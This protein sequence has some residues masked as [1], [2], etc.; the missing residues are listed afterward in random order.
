MLT[1][2]SV[3]LV[4]CVKT[5]AAAP[6]AA[7]D[8]YTSPWFRKARRYV[9]AQGGP[10]FILS[11]QHGLLHPDTV[12]APYEASLT[13]MSRT[14]RR[15]WSGRVHSQLLAR[16]LLPSFLT[17]VVFIAGER[18]RGDLEQWLTYAGRGGDDVQ[19]PLRGL[20]LGEQLA[21]LSQHT[22]PSLDPDPPPTMS[23]GAHVDWNN[24]PD[25][26]PP[27]QEENE[28]Y[29]AFLRARLPERLRRRW[30]RDAGSDPALAGLDT[31]LFRS[32][33]AS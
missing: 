16:R 20:G 18:Y 3:H 6:C 14:E 5:K 9:E 2:K 27:L 12:I 13:R 25:D 32:L 28:A 4:S 1:R 24:V 31:P 8:L 7:K 22:P 23:A 21:W 17:R 26:R 29:I 10:W 15:A 11:A 19:A 30:G 33:I